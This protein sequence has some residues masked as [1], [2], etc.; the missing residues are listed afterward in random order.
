MKL[1]EYI[2][3]LQAILERE[4]DLDVVKQNPY[5]DMVAGGGSFS[6]A[7][8]PLTADKFKYHGREFVK[9]NDQPLPP[10][11]ESNGRVVKVN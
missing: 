8:T 4:G 10:E 9:S 6:S 7:L 1:S 11:S 5:G 2:A 3:K